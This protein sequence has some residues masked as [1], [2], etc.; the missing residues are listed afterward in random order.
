MFRFLVKRIVANNEFMCPISRPTKDQRFGYEVDTELNSTAGI[1][2]RASYINHD[3]MGTARR[4][5][6]GDIMVVRAARDMDAGTEITFP[7]LKLEW[8][9]P[10]EMREVTR[11]WWNF[12]C[13]CVNCVDANNADPSVLSERIRLMDK[14][15]EFHVTHLTTPAQVEPL[16][17]KMADT[18]TRDAASVPRVSLGWRQIDLSWRFWERFEF[19]KMFETLVKAL[20]SLGFV[21]NGADFS[22]TPFEVV[23]WGY[24]DSG[25]SGSF[26]YM[27]LGFA[28]KEAKQDSE[29]A[30]NYARVAY[31]IDV[32]E[33][34]T[35]S[36][37]DFEIEHLISM[38]KAC[39]LVAS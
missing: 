18:Y 2:I 21:M 31:K 32:G 33:D 24:T 14:I 36:N 19:D 17:D 39:G 38:L 35:Y 26:Y 20:V 4:S 13:N 23:S 15:D 10:E 5:F 30:I 7:Y 1:W 29:A 16:L 27:A 34:E 22:T 11:V 6:I 9:R 37:W 8:E 3:C 12:E 25:T 28:M